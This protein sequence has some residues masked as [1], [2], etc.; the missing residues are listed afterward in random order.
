VLR[1]GHSPEEHHLAQTARIGRR[2]GDV[3]SQF[4]LDGATYARGAELGFTGLNF[5]AAGRGGVLGRVPSDVVVAAFTFIGPAM[6]RLGWDE[7][8]GLLD[9]QQAAVEFIECGYA[10]G[11]THLPASW[12]EGDDAERFVG[13][14]RRV[15]DD[16][17]PYGVPLFAAWRA[18]PWPEDAPAR[19]L[20]AVHLLRELRGGVHVMAVMAHGLDPHA[21][22]VNTS[23]AVVAEMLGWAAPHPDID[24]HPLHE[25]AEAAERATDLQMAHAFSVLTDAELD[26]LTELTGRLRG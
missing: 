17:V 2:V 18:M 15:T 13:L 24:V 25:A 14:T 7:G 26:E 3:G 21:A 9:P 1:H 6:V 12:S 16:L 10:W 5:Y 19:V 8:L 11:R 23:G 20:H 22:V 4:M